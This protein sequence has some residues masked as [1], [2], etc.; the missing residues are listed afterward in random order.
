MHIIRV[1]QFR[2]GHLLRWDWF[3]AKTERSH[4]HSWKTN[5]PQDKISAHR[6]NKRI[7]AYFDVSL[8]A[9]KRYGASFYRLGTVQPE[10]SFENRR[11]EEISA[12]TVETEAFNR[13][14]LKSFSHLALREVLP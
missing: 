12:H 4:R 2:F 7:R 8:H 13:F 10:F 14:A 1:V 11:E 9:G 5:L 6:H 3:S